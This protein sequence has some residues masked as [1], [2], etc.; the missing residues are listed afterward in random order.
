MPTGLD[1]RQQLFSLFEVA[2]SPGESSVVVSAGDLHRVLGGYPRPNHRMPVCCGVM[3][4]QMRE[5]DAI[6]SRPPSGLGASLT[7]QYVLPRARK[8]ERG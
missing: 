3:K 5:G 7:I 8:K 1:F 2:Q 4:G 6:I